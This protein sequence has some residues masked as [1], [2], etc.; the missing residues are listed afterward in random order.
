MK[1][2]ITSMIVASMLACTPAFADDNNYQAPRGEYRSYDNY[3]RHHHR[4]GGGKWVAPLIGGIVIGALLSGSSRRDRNYSSSY[5]YDNRYYPPD[6]RYDTRYCV[7][8]QVTEWH[9]GERYIFWETR[10]N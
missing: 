2:L 10:C 1:K 7:R 9:G 4:G 3:D 6:T 8:E 5:D